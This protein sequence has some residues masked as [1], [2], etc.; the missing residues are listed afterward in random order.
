MFTGQ[1]DGSIL[2]SILSLAVGWAGCC[3]RPDD[4]QHDVLGGQLGGM[5][6]R[7]LCRAVGRTCCV[8]PDHGQHVVVGGQLDRMMHSI[9]V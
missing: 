4:G 5:L 8:G 9:L 3:I 6:H 7:I 1:L 2:H